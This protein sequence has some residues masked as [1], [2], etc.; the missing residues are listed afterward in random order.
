MKGFMVSN[1]SSPLPK[2][3]SRCWPTSA[4][5]ARGFRLHCDRRPRAYRR[6]PAADH[7]AKDNIDP[8]P[9]VFGLRRPAVRE[10]SRTRGRLG[11]RL[12]GG[13][14]VTAALDMQAG[15]KIRQWCSRAG[16]H[17]KY[18]F[19]AAGPAHQRASPRQSLIEDGARLDGVCQTRLPGGR[20]DL[21]HLPGVY[22]RDQ[23]GPAR[24]IWSVGGDQ[25]VFA[26]HRRLP[27]CSG[28]L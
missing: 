18:D 1:A 21:R 27:A 10:T 4:R 28:L 22:R 17:D 19:G 9:G 15:G 24:S 23:A 5:A 12:L 6:G 13:G 20:R 14:A 25:R 2:P 16:R 11:L 8:G 26:G 3:L 7:C